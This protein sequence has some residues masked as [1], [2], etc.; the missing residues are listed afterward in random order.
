KDAGKK[1]PIDINVHFITL[2]QK[3]RKEV[4]TG[5]SGQS[6]TEHRSIPNVLGGSGKSVWLLRASDA[7]IRKYSYA[8][9]TTWKAAPRAIVRAGELDDSSVIGDA[10]NAKYYPAPASG[11]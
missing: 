2:K 6:I 5:K 8:V 7:G 11:T 9:N 1:N 3:Q 4:M 10:P